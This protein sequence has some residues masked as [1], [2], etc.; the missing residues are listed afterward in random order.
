MNLSLDDQDIYYHVMEVHQTVHSQNVNGKQKKTLLYDIFLIIV[1]LTGLRS[2]LMEVPRNIVTLEGKSS[3]EIY[4]TCKSDYQSRL[5]WDLHKNNDTR[6]DVLYNGYY[7]RPDAKSYCTVIAD[8]PGKCYLRLNNTA[9]AA[10]TY[11]CVEPGTLL[12]ASAELIWITESNPICNDSSTQDLVNLTCSIEFRGNWAPTMEWKEQR[13]DGEEV[14]SVGVNTVTVPNHRVTST[15]VTKV[16]EGSRNYS[17]STKFDISG[18]SPYTT[19]T[20]IPDY[21]RVWTAS[22][23]PKT[24]DETVEGSPPNEMKDTGLI[25]SLISGILILIAIVLLSLTLIIQFSKRKTMQKKMHEAIQ[26]ENVSLKDPDAY[27]TNLNPVDFYKPTEAQDT[28]TYRTPG[29]V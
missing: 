7:L 14:L 21:N 23:L 26:A 3:D 4:M 17:C 6:N 15:L 11:I 9:E 27:E 10:Q 29:P 20:N 16:Q 24:Q 28:E 8:D 1:L 5:K 19:A 22:V 2:E 12:H 18:K 13:N 25:A